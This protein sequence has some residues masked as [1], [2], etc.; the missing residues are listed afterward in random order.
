V[1]S[2]EEVEF[3]G[4][5]LSHRLLRP[6]S[7]YMEHLI[8]MPRPTTA[9]EMKRLTGAAEWVAAFLPN[10][11]KNMG[12]LMNA[13]GGKGKLIWS[14]DMEEAW[15]HFQRVISHYQPVSTFSNTGGGLELHVDAS[16]VGWGAVL[17]QDGK[18]I[19]CKSG[20]WVKEQLH[21]HCREQELMAALLSLRAWRVYCLSVPTVVFTDHKPNC[22]VR[23][24][25]KINYAKV[26]RWVEELMDFPVRWAHVAGVKNGL[27]DWL[28]RDEGLVVPGV[29]TGLG[30][31]K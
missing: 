16:D 5:R 1:A 30:G 8:Q 25:Q 11:R 21:W 31:G 17:I 7:Q 26:T 15:Q 27:P 9:K 3:L 22:S 14:E 19:G 28:S 18:M 6:T 13:Q 29:D 10:L 24:G 23:V 4:H 2:G 20:A 12:P